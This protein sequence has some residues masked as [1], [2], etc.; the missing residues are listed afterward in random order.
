FG[1]WGGFGWLPIGPCD[2]FHPW[3]GGYGNRFNTVNIT[4]VNI[5]NVNVYN[6]GGIAPLHNG[7]R[8]SNLARINDRHI[9]RAVSTVSATR[10]GAGPVRAVA[11]R[12]EQLRT[13]RMMTGNLPVVPT[14]ASLS[15]SGRPA[16]PTTIRGGG[17]QRFFG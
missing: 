1:G 9:G 17:Q 2:Y 12:P 6:H 3:W 16:A 7:L 11:A 4:N 14:R 8:Y 15:A 10:F 5:T 13:A